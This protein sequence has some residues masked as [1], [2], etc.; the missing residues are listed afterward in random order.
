MN[1]RDSKIHACMQWEEAEEAAEETEAAAVA[2]AEETADVAAAT[3][4]MEGDE[5]MGLPAPSS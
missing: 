3:Q 2:E 5:G 1:F 4:T